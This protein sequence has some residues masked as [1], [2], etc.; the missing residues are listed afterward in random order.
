MPNETEESDDL[1]PPT[2]DYYALLCVKVISLCC[3]VVGLA[4][5]IG[6]ILANQ[7]SVK[8]IIVPYLTMT[9]S[10][11]ITFVFAGVA[12]WF[13]QYPQNL[14][15]LIIGKIFALMVF[16]NGFLAF[17][18]FETRW[19]NIRTEVFFKTFFEI[20]YQAMP[21]VMAELS[22][23][24]FIVLGISL[25]LLH[26]KNHFL[27]ILTQVSIFLVSSLSLI[28]A[29]GYA[30]NFFGEF[31]INNNVIPTLIT[32]LLF[33]LFCVG[34]YAS[35]PRE[36]FTAI[37][38]NNTLGGYIGKRL[39]VFP[40]VAPLL[41]SLFR[42]GGV[43]SLYLSEQSAYALS[44][45][46]NMLI[47]T[48]LILWF[49][50]AIWKLDLKNREQLKNQIALSKKLQI[51]NQ[52]LEDFAYVVSHD[53]KAPLRG[54]CSLAEW[55]QVDYGDKLDE[56]GKKHL[57]LL[58]N[59][60]TRMN[61]LITGILEYSRLGRRQEQPV[62]VDLNLIVKE[63][64]EM[65]DEN[66]NITFIIDP[67]LPTV[68]TSTIQMKQIFQNLIGNSVKYMDKEKGIITVKCVQKD[69]LWEFSVE[70]NGP[71]IDSKHFEKI[72]QMFVSLAPHE[73]NDST[74]IG[75]SI[76]KKIVEL[77]EGH[78]WVESKRG[79]G[80]AFYFTLPRR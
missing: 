78:V 63:V 4:T 74:G 21:H 20:A 72:F 76:V 47:L 10:A 42:M 22:S 43:Q 11:A 32:L 33:C 9:F 75:L 40:L 71:G 3:I 12:L 65:F 23:F 64:I 14:W 67:D 66:K 35:R 28:A 17:S 59:K 8:D 37:F 27:Y 46:T 24:N 6:W 54:I 19:E 45:Y 38:T 44:V 69:E 62:P 48:F 36:G 18:I 55:L 60:T 25:F 5:S 30:F 13:L 73:Q 79:E 41:V 56:E 80:T 15:K 68:T 57:N 49:A 16:F 51:V 77:W 58:V 7:T 53:L 70:D 31:Y 1:F 52:N 50:S 39:I 29:Y 2:L 34:L 61:S 26:T